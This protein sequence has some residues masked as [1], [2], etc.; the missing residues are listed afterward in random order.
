MLYIF[1]AII[2]IALGFMIGAGILFLKTIPRSGSSES[3]TKMSGGSWDKHRI[4]L[5]ESREWLDAAKREDMSISSFDGIK[6][7][8]FYYPAAAPNGCL[9]AAFNGYRS[10][11]RSQFSHITRYL[12]G[13][14]FDAALIDDRAHGESGGKYV[15]F[16]ALDRYDCQKWAEYLDEKFGGTRKIYLYGVSMGAAAVLMASGLKLP[17]SVKGIIA[18]CGYTSA[19]DV[20]KHVL[21]KWYHLPS[22]PLL[23]ISNLYCRV[24]AK[25]GYKDAIALE[26]VKS[27][28]LP[29]LVIHGENDTFVPSYMAPEIYDASDSKYKKLLIIKNAAHAESYF[30]DT[31][32]Y[33]KAVAEFIDKTKNL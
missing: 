29:L 22:F 17:D 10:D 7:A 32:R 2:L 12:N 4:L 20:F 16:G 11:S 27:S 31:E 28:A 21:N 8:G 9:I 13:L 3:A 18:D 14:G 26:A 6:L 23:Q 24:F 19:Y 25:Y 5:K 30:I 33:R 1:A 15:G